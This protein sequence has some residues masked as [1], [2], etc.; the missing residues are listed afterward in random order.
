LIER[1]IFQSASNTIHYSQS[2]IH[3]P[4]SRILI[5]GSGKRVTG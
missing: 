4:D 2:T 1:R 5:R 3:Y